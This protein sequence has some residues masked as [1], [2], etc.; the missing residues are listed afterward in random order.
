MDNNNEIFYSTLGSIHHVD[1]S[2]VTDV[3][4]VDSAFI[5]RVEVAKLTY[6]YS[7]YGGSM[8]LRNVG[9][10]SIPCK[11]PRAELTSTM[12]RSQSLK[13][14]SYISK[15]ISVSGKINIQILRQ[16]FSDIRHIKPNNSFLY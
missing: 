4:E 9:D 15:N 11:E 12:N 13:S 1:A 3:A 6:F 5:F 14:V 10:T 7:N 8:Y 16:W 2:S